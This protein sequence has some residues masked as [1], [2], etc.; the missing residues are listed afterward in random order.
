MT[1]KKDNYSLKEFIGLQFEAMDRKLD[2]FFNSHRDL[3]KTV[4]ANKERITHINTKINTTIW[5]FSITIPV[6]IILLTYIYTK[7]LE[8][9]KLDINNSI[10][11][12]FLKE[13][14]K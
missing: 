1:E 5:A 12:A 2:G 11:K 10:E 9:T 3:E 8:Q 6:I 7:E 4:S 13:L 14:S